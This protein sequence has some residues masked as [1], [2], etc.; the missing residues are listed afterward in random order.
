MTPIILCIDDQREVLSAVVKD[1]EIF[2]KSFEIMQ[3]ES[4]KEAKELINE[5]DSHGEK[6][7]LVICDHIMPQENG[8]T[9]LGEFNSDSRFR[10]TK[11]ILLTGLASHQDTIDAINVASIDSY[12]EKPW[13]GDDLISK[14]KRMLTLFILSEGIDATKFLSLLDQELYYSKISNQV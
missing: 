4:V 13:D 11:K 10:T 9:F 7:A 5:A 12:I 3:A 1:L 2:E 6:I 14:V 8:I